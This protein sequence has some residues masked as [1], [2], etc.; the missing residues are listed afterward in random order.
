M[1]KFWITGIIF[2]G[3]LAGAGIV[4]VDKAADGMRVDNVFEKR[5]YAELSIAK[6]DS[7]PVF[8]ADGLGILISKR[9]FQVNPGQVYR[10]SVKVKAVDKPSFMLIGF[11]PYDAQE[12]LL[13]IVNISG[14]AQSFTELTKPCSAKDKVIFVKDASAWLGTNRTVAFDAKADN[15]DLPNFNVPNSSIVNIEE[16]EADNSWKVSFNYP[17]AFDRPAGTAVRM[18]RFGGTYLYTKSCDVFDKWSTVVGKDFPGS[19]FRKGTVSARAV[20]LCNYG[21][22]AKSS[23]IFDELTVEEVSK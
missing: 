4:T 18:H 21:K 1:K 11:A 13:G 12:R 8:R 5:N 22:G 20:I 23:M 19:Q 6:D 14:V 17:V 10:V 9:S 16:I 3:L 7:K 15:S 2:C